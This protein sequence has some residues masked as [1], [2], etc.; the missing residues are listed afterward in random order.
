MALFVPEL[1]FY[2]LIQGLLKELRDNYINTPNKEET[3]L[4]YMWNGVEDGKYN[5]LENAI[6][7]FTER[8]EDNPRRVQCRLAFDREKANLPSIHITMPRDET[9]DNSVGVQENWEKNVVKVSQGKI[10]PSHERRFDS[11]SHIICSS[12]NNRE[13]LLMYHTL[14]AMLISAWNSLEH[15]GVQNIKLSGQEIRMENH[16]TPPHIFM[17]GIGV[18]YSYDITIPRVFPYPLITQ[19][20]FNKPTLKTT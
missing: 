12:D 18:T 1:I 4:Y 14:R 13:V 6:S 17:R 7:L 5:Y 8:E 11:T 3:H 10:L 19:L 20:V 16:L 2:R 15:S 9:G